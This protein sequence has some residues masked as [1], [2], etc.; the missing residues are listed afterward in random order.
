MTISALLRGASAGPSGPLMGRLGALWPALLAMALA[1]CVDGGTIPASKISATPVISQ[2][3]YRIGAGDSLKI[4]V[5]RNEDLSTQVV[6]RPDG[7]IS[8]PLVNDMI[9]ASKTPSE[10]TEDLTRVL[11]EYVRNPKVNVIVTSFVGTFGD[12]IRVVGEAGH[13]KIIPYRA[14]M[15]LLDVMLEAGGLAEHA[16]GNSAKVLRNFGGKNQKISV[17]LNNLLYKGDITQNITMLP[18]DVV[19]VPLSIF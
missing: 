8:M 10:L 9:A 3:D 1:A 14:G 12:Q 4:F 16:S 5:W 7:K 18:G 2:K 19:V 17:K 15:T 13:P 11:S 6:V